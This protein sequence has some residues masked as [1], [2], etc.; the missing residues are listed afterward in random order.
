MNT[1]FKRVVMIMLVVHS[2][3]PQMFAASDSAEPT[4][5]HKDV[6]ASA[7]ASGETPLT[8]YKK[9]NKGWKLRKKAQRARHPKPVD[10]RTPQEVLQ[11]NALYIGRVGI[12][13]AGVV[14]GI[15]ATTAACCWLFIYCFGLP[16]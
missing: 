11:D 4:A 6:A 16:I 7:Q 13:S 9:K 1:I 14:A 3:A 10:N 5:A 12:I 8:S 2:I 15:Y